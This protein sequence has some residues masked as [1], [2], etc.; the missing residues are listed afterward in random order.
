[1]KNKAQATLEFAV[2]FV[3][4]VILLLSLLALWKKFSDRIIERQQ[5]YNAGRNSPMNIPTGE[6]PCSD[7]T[8]TYGQIPRDGPGS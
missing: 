7:Y 8:G 6:G 5:A 2:M 4:M 3:I 1:M